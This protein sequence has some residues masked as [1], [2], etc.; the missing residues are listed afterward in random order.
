MN[1]ALPL[2]CT[3]N[4]FKLLKSLRDSIESP[5]ALVP[6]AVAIAMHQ[7]ESA[8]P[9]QIDAKLQ[10]FADSIRSRVRGSQ[11]QALLAHMH[12]FLFDE[13]GFAGNSEDYYDSSNS[14]L[15]AV[16]ETKRGLPITLSLIYKTV[17]DRL[18]LRSWGVGLPG[19]F[20]VGVDCD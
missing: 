1:T 3:P 19:H 12:E 14:Y 17:A 2:C 13:I 20:I 18:G 8:D 10:S 7:N 11:Q 6:G 5:E 15:P 4:A 16:L 9:A